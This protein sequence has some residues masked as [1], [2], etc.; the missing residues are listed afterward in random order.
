ML[1]ASFHLIQ[2]KPQTYDGSVCFLWLFIRTSIVIAW[3]LLFTSV[4][5]I[6]HV[7]RNPQASIIMTDYYKMIKQ[8]KKKIRQPMMLTRRVKA[9]T[10]LNKLNILYI[11]KITLKEHFI[12]ICQ[13]KILLR[14]CAS[15]QSR[16]QLRTPSYP[17]NT[18]YFDELSNWKFYD[19]MKVTYVYL[20]KKRTYIQK[21]RWATKYR[22]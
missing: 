6:I 20:K 4:T 7:S 3:G 14:I 9:Y 21:W 11:Y 22:P 13:L 16:E 19:F 10:C 1:L 2:E 8:F 17:T 15:T 12:N 5:T 18:R